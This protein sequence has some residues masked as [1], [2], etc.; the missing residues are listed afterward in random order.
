VTARYSVTR[1]ERWHVAQVCTKENAKLSDAD[2]G[3]SEFV[4]QIV[5]EHIAGYSDIKHGALLQVAWTSHALIR[6]QW[7]HGHLYTLSFPYQPTFLHHLCLN[8]A[9]PDNAQPS[10]VSGRR[11][12]FNLNISLSTVPTCCEALTLPRLRCGVLA[13]V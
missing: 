2:P 6:T 3:A 13:T 4:L 8:A 9:A 7:R 11:R 5:P 12:G 10:T 1:L